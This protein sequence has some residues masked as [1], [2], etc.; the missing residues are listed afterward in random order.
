MI[1]SGSA[2]GGHYYAYIKYTPDYNHFTLNFILCSVFHQV[3]LVNNSVLSCM[4]ISLN[5]HFNNIFRSFADK[6]WYCFNDQSVSKVSHLKIFQTKNLQITQNFIPRPWCIFVQ[7]NE[8]D[9]EGTFGGP[10][11]RSRGY[12]S[13]MYAS[14]A[15]AYMLMYRR[16][17]RKSNKGSWL[18]SQV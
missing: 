9:I 14:S 4:T 11:S 7:L 13:S 17:D 10:D 5:M 1:H 8:E 12:Y 18:I 2:I 16:I 6:K 3:L 15:N